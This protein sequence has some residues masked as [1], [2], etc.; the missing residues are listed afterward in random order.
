MGDSL[1]SSSAGLYIEF[2]KSRQQTEFYGVSCYFALNYIANVGAFFS[3]GTTTSSLQ[4][5]FYSISR[6]IVSPSTL[7]NV[8]GLSKT[9]TCLVTGSLPDDSSLGRRKSMSSPMDCPYNLKD[10][11]MFIGTVN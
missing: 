6:T 1:T 11:H 9:L 3:P 7:L 5:K 2:T 10:L 4:I 8:S